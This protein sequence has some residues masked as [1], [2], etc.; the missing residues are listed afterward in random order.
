MGVL[1]RTLDVSQQKEE[2]TGVV[3]S[4]AIAG[5]HAILGMIAYPAELRNVVIGAVAAANSPVLSLEI[6]RFIAGAGA[7][8]ILGAGVTLAVT[9]QGTS[10]QQGFSLM[11]A[12]NTLVQ[13]LAGDMIGL[14]MAGGISGAVTNM[15]Y[16]YVVKP[17]QEAKAHWGTST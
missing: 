16:S 11:G 7:T 14:K 5:S 2:E 10:G 4:L 6:I 17:L 1:N 13:L 15:A 12:G 9:A 8:I 3:S